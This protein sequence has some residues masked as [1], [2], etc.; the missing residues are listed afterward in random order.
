MLQETERLSVRLVHSPNATAMD[1]HVDFVDLWKNFIFNTLQMDISSTIS[2][3]DFSVLL[4]G[5]TFN[6]FHIIHL[7]IKNVDL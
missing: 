3:I 7:W 6:V 5:F 4:N 1:K 2:T